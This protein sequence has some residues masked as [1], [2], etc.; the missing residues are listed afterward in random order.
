MTLI[1][2]W[3]V[4]NWKLVLGALLVAFVAYVYNAHVDKLIDV[5]TAKAVAERDTVWRTS[6]Q[7]AV[8]KANAAKVAE[9]SAH[10]QQLAAI[11]AQ[12]LKD[13]ANAKT[14]HDKDVAAARN[15]ALRLRVP[16]SVCGDSG[17]VSSPPGGQSPAG[18]YVELPRSLVERLFGLADDAD[19][20]T[21]NYNACL[22]V[23]QSDRK[24]TP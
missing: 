8:A 6:E 24:V 20:L 14:Q 10:Q 13:L 22:Q 9:E 19:A 2:S 11:E 3:L 7:Q 21:A 16:A 4:G 5:A 12:H 23:I 15:G 17:N 1:L 18:S